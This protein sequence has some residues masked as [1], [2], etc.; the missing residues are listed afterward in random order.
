MFLAEVSGPDDNKVVDLMTT[1]RLVDVIGE[2]MP[3]KERQKLVEMTM[4]ALTVA[5]ENEKFVIKRFE[6]KAAALKEGYAE[7]IK[8]GDWKKAPSQEVLTNRYELFVEM[9][10]K[11]GVGSTNQVSWTPFHRK[12]FPRGTKEKLYAE[13][14]PYICSWCGL[15]IEYIDH[16]ETDHINPVANGGLS[17]Y[18]N[19]Q[20]LH[21]TCNRTKGA[22]VQS[23]DI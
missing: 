1:L 23:S 3:A 17:T 5:L 18:E 13:K 9:L 6:Q 15:P 22:T 19:A 14:L 4:V 11:C 7:L 16:A 21:T 10:Q 20:L 12:P 8:K 2:K